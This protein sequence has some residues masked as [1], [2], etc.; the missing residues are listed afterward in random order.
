MFVTQSEGLQLNSDVLRIMYYTWD[1]R[2]F[3]LFPSSGFLK[4]MSSWKLDL[5]LSFG[6]RVGRHTVRSF[7]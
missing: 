6:E 2:V 4:S 5:F 1:Y 7:K 3:G